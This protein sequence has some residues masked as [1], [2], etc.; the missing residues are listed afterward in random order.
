MPRFGRGSS[1]AAAGRS[2]VCRGGALA[3]TA[4]AA[5]SFL[6]GYLVYKA[7]ILCATYLMQGLAGFVV[8]FIQLLY[9]AGVPVQEVKPGINHGILSLPEGR[10]SEESRQT[11]IFILDTHGPCGKYGQLES[12]APVNGPRC[13]MRCPSYIY[14]FFSAPDLQFSPLFSSF[15]PPPYNFATPPYIFATKI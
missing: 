4:A 6:A 7:S 8:D 15:R 3:S 10:H 12:N 14:I 13:V 1:A 5:P 11:G 9:G 2:G